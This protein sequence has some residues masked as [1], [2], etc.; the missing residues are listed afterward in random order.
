MMNFLPNLE[1]YLV[2]G[3]PLT[4]VQQLRCPVFIAHAKNDDNAPFDVTKTYV[5]AIRRAGG[6]VNFLE[7]EREGHYQPLL[8]A[9]IP[10]ALEW[11]K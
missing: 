9:G 11:L 8:E 10:Q 4:H 7:L 6:K 2:S 3:S 5:E 1:M